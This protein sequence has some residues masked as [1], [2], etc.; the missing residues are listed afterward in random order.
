M[1]LQ[2][3][4][5]STSFVTAAG[6]ARAVDGVTFDV[7]AGEMVALV[8]ESGCGKT[9]IAL[10]L[11]RLLPPAGRVVRGSALLEGRDLLTLDAR[12]LR[13]LRGRRISLIFQEPATALNPVRSI[14]DQLAEVARVHGERSPRVAWARGI[15]MLERTGIPD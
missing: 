2:V 7:A 3:R 14:G 15:A 10:S 11:M 4:D 9:A 12:T 13:D 8:G 6:V 5:L 1:C